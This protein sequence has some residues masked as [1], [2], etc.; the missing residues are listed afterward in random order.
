MARSGG[1]LRAFLASALGTGLSRVLGLVRD[2]ALSNALGAGALNDAFQL[3]FTMPNAFRRFVADEGLTGALIPTLADAEGKEGA[4]RARTLAQAAFT[5][6]MLV[7]V[8]VSGI[9]IVWAEG[10]VWLFAAPSWRADPALNQLAISLTRIMMPL[11]LMVSATSFF[12]ALL[13]L[14]G[15]FFVPKIAPGLISAGIV[16]GLVFLTR[17]G[18]DPVYAASWG[19]VIGGV[20]HVAIN[21]PWVLKLWGVVA[22]SFAW[23]RPR[24]ALLLREMGKVALIGLAAQANLLV[25]RQLAT[26]I[27]VGS[28]TQYWYA[29]RLI[30]LAQGIIAVAVGSA[31]LPVVARAV[32]DE[33]WPGFRRAM[34]GALRLLAFVLLPSAVVIGFFSTPLVAVLFRHGD[35]SWQATQATAAALPWF[36]PF[37][38]AVAGINVVKKVYFALND[39]TT[40]LAIGAVGVVLTAVIGWLLADRYGVPG[41]SA[42]LSLSTVLQFALYIIVLQVRLGDRMAL[43][44]LAL[45]FLRMSLACVPLV[46]WLWWMSTLGDWEQGPLSGRNWLVFCGGGL[47]AIALYLVAATAL[48]IEELTEVTG[49]L[50]RRFGRK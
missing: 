21:I 31:L 50:G 40:L 37:M 10:L 42:A 15:H 48:R 13:N 43:S 17:A 11:L 7:C 20:L 19:V 2:V 36:T 1:F 24:M 12:E 33:D 46:P 8:V 4:E 22:P 29:N 30:D 26:S 27:E 23:R 18:Q 9:G 34:N 16:G 39:R 44:A 35:F 49:R 5:A 45:P 38:L 47:G 25:I 32:V 3:A 14:R 6:L 28:L 41:V